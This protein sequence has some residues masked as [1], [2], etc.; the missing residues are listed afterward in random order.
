VYAAP[1]GCDSPTALKPDLTAYEIELINDVD[2]YARVIVTNSGGTSATSILVYIVLSEDSNLQ[3][4]YAVYEYTINHLDVQGT[5]EN[6]VL[7]DD[8]NISGIPE[9]DY[10][11]GA[12][13]DPED[14]IDEMTETNNCCASSSIITITD[15]GGG[16]YINIGIQ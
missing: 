15:G 4:Y 2:P 6:E 13:V 10:Y 14:D 1:D 9:G 3:S 12:V 8:F 11:A 5:D 16:G 7:L